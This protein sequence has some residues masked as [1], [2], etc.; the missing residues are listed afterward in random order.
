MVPTAL[1]SIANEDIGKV[2]LDISTPLVKETEETVSCKVDT[3][4]THSLR[5]DTTATNSNKVE[6]TTASN[7]QK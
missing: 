5:I 3:S 1:L 7:T 2:T 4:A 6:T